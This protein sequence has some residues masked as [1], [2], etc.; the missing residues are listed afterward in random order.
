[1]T[2]AILGPDDP[3]LAA[4]QDEIQARPEIDARLDIVPWA[5]YQARLQNALSADTSPY[6]A[7]CAPGHM[8]LPDLVAQRKLQ[9][10]DPL[11]AALPAQRRAD[12]GPDDILPSVA[13]ECR[14]DGA[15]YM[16]PLFTDG[17]LVFYRSDLVTLP[18]FV[19]ARDWVG[20][21]AGWTLPEGMWPLAL[22]ADVSE[23][24][25]DWLPMLWAYGGDV[26]DPHGQPRFND[27]LGQRALAAYR[28][29]RA[30]AHPDSHTFGNNEIAQALASGAV[31]A[32]VSWGGQAAAIFDPARNPWHAQIKTAQLTDPWNATWG[33]CLPAHQTEE[34][35]RRAIEACVALTGPSFDARVTRIAGSPTRAGSYS[36]SECARYPW[37][38]DQRDMLAACR[39]LPA[40]A[41]RG[42]LL[43]MLYRAIHRAFTGQASPAEALAEAAR[44]AGAP[45]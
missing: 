26:L 9:A 1:M 19:C 30:W 40:A 32:A 24:L 42:P 28:E 21:V 35:A 38:A 10:L 18:K 29:L 15:P 3:A 37:L 14:V 41:T 7:V 34:S 44:S 16:L 33:I 23:I 36:E 25:L 6:Q 11:L 4:L 20:I 31:A 12:Y 45:L 22:K 13:R 2:I 43:G 8:W 5:E 39:T 27:A 17:H